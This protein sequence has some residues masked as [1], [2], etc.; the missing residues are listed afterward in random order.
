[1]DR[2]AIKDVLYGGLVEL[3]NNRKFYYNS[4]VNRHYCH[5]TDEG[6]AAVKDYLLLMTPLIM[7]SEDR[8][9]DKRA[10]E[11]VLQDLKS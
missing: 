1:M 3:A 7:D 6:E 5:W 9:L 11:L 2:D 10:R 8:T 4:S